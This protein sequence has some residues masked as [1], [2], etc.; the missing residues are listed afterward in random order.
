MNRNQDRRWRA[1]SFGFVLLLVGAMLLLPQKRTETEG[2]A[3]NW[4]GAYPAYADSADSSSS[5]NQEPYN[6]DPTRPHP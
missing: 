2:K 1:L 3:W 6:D 5:N 4:I